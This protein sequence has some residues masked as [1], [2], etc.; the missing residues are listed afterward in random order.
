M[1]RASLKTLLAPKV[2]Q[3]VETAASEWILDGI[4]IK[5]VGAESTMPGLNGKRDEETGIHKSHHAP[6]RWLLA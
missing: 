1:D 3:R 6:L 2:L 5:L 4:E